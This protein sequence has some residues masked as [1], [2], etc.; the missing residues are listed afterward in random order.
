MQRIRRLHRNKRKK[1]SLINLIILDGNKKAEMQM[2]EKCRVEAESTTELQR[3]KTASKSESPELFVSRNAL[4]LQ[5]F[6][7][8]LYW[9]QLLMESRVFVFLVRYHSG[10]VFLAQP[11]EVGKSTKDRE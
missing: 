10:T 11:V 5:L 6:L 8:L 1:K 7:L 3:V 2:E 9:L 4:H